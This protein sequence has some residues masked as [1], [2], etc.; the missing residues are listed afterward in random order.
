MEVITKLMVIGGK[1]NK[2]ITKKMAP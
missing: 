1:I 2:D